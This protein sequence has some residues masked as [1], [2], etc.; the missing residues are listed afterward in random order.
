MKL[1]SIVEWLD[2][3]TDDRHVDNT[4]DLIERSA[5]WLDFCPAA[6]AAVALAVFMWVIILHILYHL[7]WGYW[8][9]VTPH[10][11]H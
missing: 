9:G 8:R 6:G 11:H 2:H 1:G 4:P 3:L 10:T 7:L 5:G